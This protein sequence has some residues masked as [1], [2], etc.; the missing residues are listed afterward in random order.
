MVVGVVR[1]GPHH[2]HRGGHPG[3]LPMS[4][5]MV[6]GRAGGTCRHHPLRSCR[7]GPSSSL[8]SIFYCL[9]SLF[10]SWLVVRCRPWWWPS[11]RGS[12]SLTVV[13][14]VL[15]RFLPCAHPLW[16]RSL[17]SALCSFLVVVVCCYHS[18][19]GGGE[20]RRLTWAQV[21]QREAYIEVI[22]YIHH[23]PLLPCASTSFLR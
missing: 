15:V 18:L 19:S 3:G 12:T 13:V 4:W 11:H 10:A 22:P 23:P 2:V 5:S 6:V 1:G 21:L 16:S 20:G 8:L 9:S 14:A 17:L 7:I